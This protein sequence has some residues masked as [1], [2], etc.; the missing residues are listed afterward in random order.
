MKPGGDKRITDLEA[1]I[2]VLE[3]VLKL[4]LEKHITDGVLTETEKD[5]IPK[6][7]WNF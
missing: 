3:A 7:I 1:R 4:L 2:T 5:F 6:A